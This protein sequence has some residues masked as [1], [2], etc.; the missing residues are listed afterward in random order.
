[1]SIEFKQTCFACPE[2]YDAVDDGRE[3]GYLRLRHGHFTVSR[4]PYSPDLFERSFPLTW[5]SESLEPEEYTLLEQGSPT[6]SDGIFASDEARNAYLSIA[7]RYISYDQYSREYPEPEGCF[8]YPGFV[9]SN[10]LNNE[11]YLEKSCQA[12]PEWADILRETHAKLEELVPGYNIAQIKEKFGGLRYYIGM[13][14]SWYDDEVDEED[15]IRYGELSGKAHQITW[16]AEARAIN[17]Y[18][19]R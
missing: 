11:S 13:P 9:K 10:P 16:D 7:R 12:L 4:S 18:D 2:Q 14:D 5:D 17:L 3:V 15:A 6:D 1:M 19:L 8:N